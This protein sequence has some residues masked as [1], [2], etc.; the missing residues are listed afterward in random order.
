VKAFCWVLIVAGSI[1][2][3]QYGAVAAQAQAIPPC[4]GVAVVARFNVQ[5]GTCPTDE[6]GG[7]G[8]A[9]ISRRGSTATLSATLGETSQPGSAEQVASWWE[10][11]APLD[12]SSEICVQ[13][14]VTRLSLVQAGG[15][16]E[17]FTVYWNYARQEHSLVSVTATGNLT[18]CGAVPAGVVNVGWQL[19]TLATAS[20]PESKALVS[21]TLTDVSVS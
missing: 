10:N 3:L 16:Q 1:A 19:I 18:L 14:S 20:S 9:E 11:N 13:V 8:S 5:A 17:D 21:E 15:V 4:R 2:T 12:G 7:T 6:N